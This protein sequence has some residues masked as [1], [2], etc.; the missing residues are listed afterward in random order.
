ML[1]C[2]K[3]RLVSPEG[4]LNCECG[5]DFRTHSGGGRKPAAVL[6]LSKWSILVIALLVAFSVEIVAFK[7]LALAL[8]WGRPSDPT[9]TRLT[10]IWGV[11]SFF[12]HF[13]ALFVALSNRSWPVI[14]I[15]GYI[16][17]AI[18]VFFAVSVIRA[19]FASATKTRAR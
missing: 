12:I 16:E 17:L 3:C 15:V 14:F 9:P 8:I 2:P 4:S 5:Y 7:G 1:H 18:L 10:E 11:L 13:P 19:G 6:V